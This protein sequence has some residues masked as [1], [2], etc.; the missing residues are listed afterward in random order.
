[1]SVEA[2]SDY[3][4]SSWLKSFRVLGASKY[5]QKNCFGTFQGVRGHAPVENVENGASQIG[6]KMH[7]LLIVTAMK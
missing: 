5:P 2:E 3:Q 1:M 4:K 6:L 7:F